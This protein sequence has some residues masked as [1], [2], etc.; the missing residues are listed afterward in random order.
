MNDYSTSSLLIEI[1][2]RSFG[3]SLLADFGFSRLLKS[4]S[5]SSEEVGVYLKWKTCDNIWIIIV[6][7]S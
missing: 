7:N 2:L 5:F 3:I 6:F 1:K 4:S